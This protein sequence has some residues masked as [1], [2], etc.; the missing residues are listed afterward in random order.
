MPGSRP[1]YQGHRLKPYKTKASYQVKVGLP[2]CSEGVVSALS[3]AWEAMPT[4]LLQVTYLVTT[5]G[6]QG[7]EM[8]TAL[9]KTRSW[10]CYFVG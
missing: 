7:Q 9:S 5:G 2:S 4:D 10:P 3:Q 8:E 6:R 1:K